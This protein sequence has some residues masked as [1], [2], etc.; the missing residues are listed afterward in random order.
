M[1]LVAGTHYAFGSMGPKIKD[2][3]GY[4]QVRD[5][6]TAYISTKLILLHLWQILESMLGKKDSK[7]VNF[8]DYFHHF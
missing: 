6:T 4:S 3:M 8:E 1:M 2:Y 5:F 7:T